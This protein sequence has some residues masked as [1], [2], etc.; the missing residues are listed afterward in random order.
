MKTLITA[1]ALTALLATT[2]FASGNGGGNPGAGFLDEWDTNGDGQVTV[3]DVASRRS[4]VFVS[5][6][7]DDNGILDAEEYAFFD[8]AR[9]TSHDGEEEKGGHGGERKA[10]VGMTLPFNDVDGDGSVSMEEFIGQSAAWLALVDRNGDGV[11]TTN[12]FGPNR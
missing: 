3:E 4:D 5:F 7:A 11:V 12:D 6:D 8:E 1:T 2:A 9:A 10:A